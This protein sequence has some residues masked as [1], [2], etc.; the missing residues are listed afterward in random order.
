MPKMVIAVRALS[1]NPIKEEVTRMKRISFVSLLIS[2]LCSPLMGYAQ[3]VE[4]SGSP[5]ATDGAPMPQYMRHSGEKMII[6]DPRVHVWGAYNANGKLIRWGIAA[7]G[8]NECRE[9]RGPCRTNPGSYRI[10]SLGGAD[11]VSHKYDNAAMPYCMF[12]N[13]SEALHGSSDVQFE[14]ISHGC[15]R[16]HVDDAQWLRYHFVEGPVATNNYRGTKIIIKPY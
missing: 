9:T 13:G 3:M 16:I 4:I 10:Y 6:V 8:A 15:V 12:F 5:F 2:I 1:S 11:C 14:N 7:A